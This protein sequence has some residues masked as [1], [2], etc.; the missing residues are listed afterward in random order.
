MKIRGLNIS[1]LC[2][3]GDKECI[4]NE[5]LEQLEKTETCKGKFEEYFENAYK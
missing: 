4:R 1:Q 2:K 5:I 3:N